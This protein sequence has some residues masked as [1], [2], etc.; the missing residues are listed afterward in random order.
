MKIQSVTL[1]TPALK[2]IVDFYQ[3]ALGLEVIT[4]DPG[5]AHIRIGSSWLI[6]REN[7]ALEGIYH[8]AFNIP[9][10]QIREGMAWLERA[11]ISLI[12]NEKGETQIDFPN[13]NAEA[14]YFFDP[15]GNI[16]EIIARRDL[17]NE[18][19][20]PFTPQSLTEIS[21]IGIVTDDV[22]NWNT[23]AETEFGILPFDKQKPSPDFS[24]LGTNMG[25][26]IVVRA[27]R[28]WF[29]TDIPAVNVPL[30]VRFEN[31][32]GEEFEL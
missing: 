4:A 26:F 21:E 2:P 15:A 1:E 18:S 10:N 17:Q 28:N 22:P 5:M 9:G 16:V 24:A 19:D 27:G 32:R 20:H 6:F 3:S 13:W 12:A 23:R 7:A 25:L 14:A 29:L 30:K 31:D 11:G 8:F